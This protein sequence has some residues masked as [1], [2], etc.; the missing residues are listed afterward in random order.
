MEKLAKASSSYLSMEPNYFPSDIRGNGYDVD[1]LSFTHDVYAKVIEDCRYFYLKEPIASTVINKMIDIAINDILVSRNKSVSKTEFQVYDALRKDVIKFLKIAAEELLITGLVVPEIALTRLTREQLREKGI[2]R[3]DTLLYPTEMYIRDS[4][5]IDIKRPFISS[6]ES[7]F[8]LVPDDIIYFVQNKGMYP[9]GSEDKRLYEEIT[10]LYPDFIRLILK[11]ETKI[12]L[13]N[14]LIIKFNNKSFSPYP[15]SY[16]YPGL[17]SFKHKRNMRRMDYSIAARVIS[18][19]LHVTVGSDEYP[20]TQDQEDVLI[21]LEQKFR[22]RDSLTRDDVE[23][24]FTLFTNHTVAMK[25]VFPD[26]TPLLDDKKYAEV[27]KDIIQALGFPRVL[28][29]GE[30]E[31][32]FSADPELVTLSPLST[33]KAIR[34]RLLPIIDHIFRA[35]KDNNQVSLKNIPNYKFRPINLMSLTLFY[36]GLE[37]LYQSGNL[38]RDSYT[39]AFGYDFQSEV[40]KRSEEKDLLE[41]LGIDEFAPLPHSNTPG[42]TNDKGAPLGNKNGEQ[43]G[44]TKT[45]EAD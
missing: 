41:E 38:S 1:K 17:E 25:W 44:K 28:I 15:V 45:W 10:R 5:T 27:N 39:E 8:L 33:L 12:L 2:Q 7:Y 34:Q 30:S 11:G 22:W 21:Q 40:T 13:D 14:P 29:T 32:S 31:R 18:A 19:I 43:K 6:Q 24:V 23:R 26:I 42:Q 20:L 16:L 37:K 36:T 4:A 3:L 9:D 35:V